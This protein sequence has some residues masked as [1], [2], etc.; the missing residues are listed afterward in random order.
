MNASYMDSHIISEI[1][2][3]WDLRPS[4]FQPREPRFDADALLELAWI[5]GAASTVT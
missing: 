5:A 3:L 1:I 2:P 4:R